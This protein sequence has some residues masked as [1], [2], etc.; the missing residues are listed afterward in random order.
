MQA[1]GFIGYGDLAWKYTVVEKY[2]R[3]KTKLTTIIISHSILSI[4]N[5]TNS[6]SYEKVIKESIAKRYTGEG[7][8]FKGEGVFGS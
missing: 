8:Y 3:G 2:A 1:R 4:G 5:I 6:L 7:R